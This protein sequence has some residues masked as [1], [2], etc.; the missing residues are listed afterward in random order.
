M[1]QSTSS[2]CEKAKREVISS[3]FFWQAKDVCLGKRPVKDFEDPR[4]GGKI[5]RA[6]FES[7]LQ[8]AVLCVAK[9]S[10]GRPTVD[11]VFEE[12]DKAWKNT[13]IDMVFLCILP[14]SHI[15]K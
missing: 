2:P 10:K 15:Q 7:I 5:N 13:V 6:D 1:N 12:I 4:L 14:I 3:Y 11:V 9:S 8:I